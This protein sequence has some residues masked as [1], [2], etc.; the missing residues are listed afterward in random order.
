MRVDFSKFP[1]PSADE[2]RFV[3][4]ARGARAVAA[5][6]IVGGIVVAAFEPAPPAPRTRP[7]D[8]R[9]EEARDY[10]VVEPHAA[11]ASAAPTS[12]AGVAAVRD[13]DRALGR[14]VRGN[15]SRG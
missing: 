2:L 7:T 5:A 10:A 9:P 1:C 3:R 14:R 15:E 11:M 4:I 6:F 12:R 13:G 8:A